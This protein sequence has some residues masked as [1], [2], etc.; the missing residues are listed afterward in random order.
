MK[1]K[2]RKE[3]AVCGIVAE[4]TS[5]DLFVLADV[6]TEV[7]DQ[8]EHIRT[9]SAKTFEAECAIKNAVR[10]LQILDRLLTKLGVGD[11]RSNLLEDDEPAEQPVEHE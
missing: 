9:T 2:V 10:S 11:F 8:L 5:A 6:H 4:F 3:F 7:K 1:T